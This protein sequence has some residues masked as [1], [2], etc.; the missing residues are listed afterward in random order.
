MVIILI[1]EWYPSVWQIR[2]IKLLSSTFM[3]VLLLTMYKVVATFT[4]VEW[5]AE[6]SILLMLSIWQNWSCHS[7]QAC[8][9]SW[10]KRLILLKWYFF[11]RG[12]SEQPSPFQWWTSSCVGNHRPVHGSCWWASLPVIVRQGTFV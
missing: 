2:Y 9:C 7:W 8:T 3:W 4:S 1:C 10:F 11:S 12:K 5:K 6:I